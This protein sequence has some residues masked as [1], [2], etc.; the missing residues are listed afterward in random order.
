MVPLTGFIRYAHPLALLGAAYGV[1]YTHVPAEPYGFKIPLEY[2]NKNTPKSGFFF[3][4]D[5]NG[6]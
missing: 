4:G 5:P 1:A 2:A 6:I 3:N